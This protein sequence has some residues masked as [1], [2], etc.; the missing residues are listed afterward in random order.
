MSEVKKLR[1]R[2]CGQ[3]P[4]AGHVKHEEESALTSVNCYQSTRRCIW[5]G[6]HHR[7]DQ[8]TGKCRRTKFECFLCGAL[9][10]K[11]LQGKAG[12]RFEHVQMRN[13]KKWRNEREKSSISWACPWHKEENGL[14]KPHKPI[15]QSVRANSFPAPAESVATLIRRGHYGELLKE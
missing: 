8:K 13:T 14:G 7:Q 9:L 1:A 4:P 12:W 3:S 11:G 10:R 6:S 15:S 5:D 2:E